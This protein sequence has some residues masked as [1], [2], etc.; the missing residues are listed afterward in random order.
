MSRLRGALA[1][2]EIGGIQTTVP[3]HLW[4]T[5]HAPFVDA[6]MDTGLVGRDWDPEPLRL[7]A[8]RIGAAAIQQAQ[9]VYERRS[10]G[11]AATPTGT[12]TP[13]STRPTGSGW[14]ETARREAT[15][16]WP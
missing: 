7:E 4:L 9:E 10:T 16:R 14:A 3:F 6:T 1:E 12:G 11:G 8:A 5:G 13:A 15:E 2:W